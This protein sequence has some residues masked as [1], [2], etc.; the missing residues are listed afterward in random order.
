MYYIFENGSARFSGTLNDCVELASSLM[1]AGIKY[2]FV[3]KQL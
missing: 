3:G 2:L 1:D